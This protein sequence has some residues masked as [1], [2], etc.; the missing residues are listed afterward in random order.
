MITARSV[1]LAAVALALTILGSWNAAGQGATSYGCPM[2]PDT[3]SETPGTCPLCGMA[4]VRMGPPGLSP[5]RVAVDTTPREAEPGKKLRLRFQIMH[6]TTGLLVRELSIVHDMPFHLFVVSDDLAYY[7][8]IHPALEPDGAFVV[9]TVFPT[10]GTYHLFCDFLPVGGTPQVIHQRLAT[11]GFD[12]TR[13]KPPRR[14]TQ[15]AVLTKTVDGIRFELTLEPRKVAAGRAAALMYHLV[16][17]RTGAPVSDLEPYLGAWGHTLILSD[18]AERFLHSHPTQMIPAG[19]DRS[20]LLGG[21]DVSFNATLRRPGMH[22][23][24]SQFKRGGKVTTVS[25]TIDVAMLDHLAAWNGSAWSELGDGPPGGPDGTVRALA[26]RGDELFAGGDF[27]LA[28]GESVNGIARWDGRRW[29]PLGKGVDGTVRAIAVGG[30]DVYVGGE[31]TTAGGRAVNAITRWDGRTVS[32]L[33][34]GLTGSRDALRP[35][36]VYAIAVRG[37]DVYVGG[38]FMTA[39]GVPANGIA[40]WDGERFTA[41]GDGVRSGE[42][43][44]I[45][46]TMTFFRDELYVGGQF[47]TAGEVAARNIARWDGK[48]WSAVGGGVA[49]GLEKVSSLAASGNRLY[50]GGDFTM[51]GD[52]AANKLATWDGTRWQPL[53]VR[54]SESIRAITSDGSDVYVA[55]GSFTLRDGGKTNGIVKWDGSAWTALGS[56]LGSGAFLAPVLTMAAAGRT[57]YVGGGPFIVP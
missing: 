14:L 51:A 11:A 26:T 52:V 19:V 55:G 42:F 6:P 32:S 29:R 9:E 46:W 48:R 31:F 54:T 50:V 20:H 43:D 27:A 45:V 17:D 40:R 21:P 30:S 28:G 25:F 7:D 37:G 44:G 41:L 2:H 36:A 3:R 33:G 4:L 10:P 1:P 15:D 47:L 5:Y 34:A 12:R 18:D 8:H 23:L 35:T 39:G 57:V 16:D 38:R 56:G 24:W 49:G 13:P 53:A 22:R